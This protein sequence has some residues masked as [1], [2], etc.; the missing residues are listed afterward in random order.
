[1]KFYF[2]TIVTINEKRILFYSNLI[3]V[4]LRTN[5]FGDDEGKDMFYF[6]FNITNNSWKREEKS[7]KEQK[8]SA[9]KI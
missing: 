5:T 1:M 6:N 2:L 8:F 3:L 9:I 4:S 7:E